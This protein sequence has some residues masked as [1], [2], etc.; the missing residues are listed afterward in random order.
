MRVTDK[1]LRESSEEDF[2]K[3][4]KALA[5]AVKRLSDEDVRKLDAEIT[6]YEKKYGITSEQMQKEITAGAREETF[7]I[8]QWLLLIR[9]FELLIDGRVDDILRIS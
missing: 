7:E 8:C 3:K 2:T 6:A 5:D 4:L 1:E 9:R